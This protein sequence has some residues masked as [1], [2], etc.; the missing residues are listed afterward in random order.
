MNELS[1]KELADTVIEDIE[2]PLLLEAIYQRWGYDFRNYA[3]ASLKRRVRRILELEGLSSV[4]ALQERVLRDAGCMQRFIEQETVAVTSM[5]RDPGF[6]RSFRELAVPL[7]RQQPSLRI[8]QAGCASGEE[9][10]SLAILL[11]EE[12]LLGNTHLYATDINQRNLDAAREGIYP[13]EKMKEYTENYQAAGGRAAFSEYY[14]ASHGAVVMRADLS[15]HI[16]WAMHNLVT[17]A[18]FNEFDLIICR[19]VLIYFNSTLQGRVHR[20]F[21]ESLKVGGLLV[22]GRQE[23]LQL[24]PHESCFTTLDARE[25][26]YQRVR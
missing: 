26:I 5:F 25:K 22:L 8:W 11:H 17:D 1:L 3:V 6:Y 19:N 23:T 9:V 7:L 10:Y 12:G 18:S 24:T 13:L 20:L 21:F 2:I 14:H 16:V 4:S 15:K